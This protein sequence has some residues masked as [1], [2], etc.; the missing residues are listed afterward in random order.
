MLNQTC[1]PTWKGLKQPQMKPKAEM[2]SSVAVTF[3]YSSPNTKPHHLSFS[4]TPEFRP[5]PFPSCITYI[6]SLVFSAFRFTSHPQ[7]Y[8]SPCCQMILLK[9]RSDCPS[10]SNCSLLSHHLKKKSRP[11][12]RAQ[13]ALCTSLLPFLCTPVR[14]NYLQYLNPFPFSHRS[15]YC[16]ALS[17]P[18]HALPPHSE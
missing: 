16:S 9:E 3:H 18:C 4:S 5:S 8:S 15:C 12:G 13:K 1:I 17:K 14:M 10:Y 11:L 2:E 7:I 6:N